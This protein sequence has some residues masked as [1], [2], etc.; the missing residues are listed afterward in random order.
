MGIRG[1]PVDVGTTIGYRIRWLGVSITWVSRITEF[2]RNRRFV[3]VQIRGPY[4]SWRHEHTFWERHG[5]TLMRDGVHHELPLGI[6]GKIVH[7]LL[8][9][10]QLSAI[11]YY[12][13]SHIGRILPGSGAGTASPDST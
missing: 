11:F 4:R 3:D 8:V 12:R 13:V 6:L 9:S 5:E 10:P 2:E 7:R 1:S